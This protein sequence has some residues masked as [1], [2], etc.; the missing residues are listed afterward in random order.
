[1]RTKKEP[2][3]LEQQILNQL[4]AGPM[5]LSEIIVRLGKNKYTDSSVATLLS[6]MKAAGLVTSTRSEEDSR[7]LKYAL[8]ATRPESENTQSE[9]MQPRPEEPSSRREMVPVV[10]VYK[11]PSPGRGWKA[12]D[13]YMINDSDPVLVTE[14]G[15]FCLHTGR[16]LMIR[17]TDTATPI[18]GMSLK[19]MRTIEC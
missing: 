2:S 17:D 16:L 6:K 7:R 13:K 12:G 5:F 14:H 15:L 11:V 9:E 3:T 4:T 18:V 10:P 1:M 8:P 19:V